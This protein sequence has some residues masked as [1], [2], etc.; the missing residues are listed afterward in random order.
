MGFDGS[1]K[2]KADHMLQMEMSLAQAGST[3]FK[4]HVVR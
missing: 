2:R 1:K 3:I 4:A